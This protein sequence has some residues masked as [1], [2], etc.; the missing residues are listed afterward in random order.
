[1]RACWDKLLLALVLLFA[2]PAARAAI[3]C[4]IGSPGVSINYVNNTTTSVQTFFTVSC[5]R[6]SASDPTTLNYE[7]E[8]D[9]G[10]Q[11]NGQNNN[12]ILGTAT[13]RYDVFQNAGCSAPWRGN[14][15]IKDSITWTGGSTG[16]ITKQ[17]YF[18]GCMVTAQT[19]VNTG[20]YV[21]TVRMTMA[22]GTNQTAV[23]QVNVSIYAPALCTVTT[24]ASDIVVSYA[25]FGPAVTRSTTFAVTCTSGMPYTVTTDVPEAVLSGLRYTLT[26][27]GTAN[28]GTGAP[29]AYSVTATLPGGQPGACAIG[30][31]TAS[32]THIL[33]IAY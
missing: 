13:L 21:D 16:T 1:M 6:S 7:V 2:L 4:T 33:T 3:T 24:P 27:S 10:R 19:A 9:N 29:Q 20:T 31:C 11:F 28:N 15:S 5:T 32:R 23:G 26:L 18:W 14:K 17:T 30:S 25:A 22:Y 12:A 8:A